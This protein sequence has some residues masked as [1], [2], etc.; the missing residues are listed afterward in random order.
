M[1]KANICKISYIPVFSIYAF[2]PIIH[3]VIPYHNGY[4]SEDWLAL[5][6]MYALG[7]LISLPLYY[8]LSK[9]DQS[10]YHATFNSVAK[11]ALISIFFLSMCMYFFWESSVYLYLS[12]SAVMGL[13]TALFGVRRKGL[14]LIKDKDTGNVYEVRGS[15]AYKLTN[16]ELAGFKTGMFGKE[17][18]LSEFSSS[19]Y[20]GI[21]SSLSVLPI[22]NSS[23]GAISNHVITINP[24]SGMP[25]VGGISGL[26]I[27]GNSWGTNFN[28][29]S[30][31][32]DPNRGY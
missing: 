11:R 14:N 7:M 32:Y 29:P 28:E 16:A 22:D 23:G 24:T 1:L 8:V 21:D 10:A 4:D 6:G 26:D 20:S 30:N 15:K 13:S 5:I 18:T 3:D 19:Q 27:H 17:I 2:L 9:A 31:T 25:M 12:M